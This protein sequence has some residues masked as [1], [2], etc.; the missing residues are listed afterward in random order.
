MGWRSAAFEASRH[1]D[2]STISGSA[3]D[4]AKRRLLAKALAPALKLRVSAALL[5]D[6][7]EDGR[8]GIALELE[9]AIQIRKE[10]RYQA[11]N[12]RLDL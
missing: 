8:A 10:E 3:I 1:A 4:D 11:E 12:P 9:A 5:L 2:N 7:L 6:V